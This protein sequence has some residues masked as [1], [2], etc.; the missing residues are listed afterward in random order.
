MILKRQY[1]CFVAGLADLAFD[2]TKSVMDMA[3][4]REELKTILHP[5]DYLTLSVLFLP[6]DN[7]N[8][9]AFLESKD[10]TW[11]PLG[12]Y[13]IQDFE[14]Q[15]RIINSILKENN[16]LPEYMVGLMTD[17]FNTEGGIDKFEM[18]KRLTEGYINIALDSGNRFLEK[19]ISFDR[20]L[21]NIFILLN[22]KSLNLDA[23]MYIIG[24]DPF[25]TELAGIFNSGKDF[26][27]PA[28]PEY[29]H[30]I[31]KIATENEFL[32]RERKIDMARWDFIDSATF[33][34]YFTLDMIIGYLIK[35]SIVLRWKQLDPET[36][37]M[38]LEKLIE[39]MESP[40][41][42]GNYTVK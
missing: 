12:N 5:G 8:L 34:E 6:H 13:S 11:D 16:I 14:E 21:N 39:D 7:K 22:S 35:L 2:S 26:H 20:D 23:N 42:T 27:I 33:F 32:D 17:W 19:W 25:A 18:D 28:E 29:A 38:M 41:L 37:K 40:V 31:F 10:T 15:E 1:H 30:M 9:I 4:F 36:G 3:E 24:D